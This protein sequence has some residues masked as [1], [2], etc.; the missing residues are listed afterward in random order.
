MLYDRHMESP[1]R[2]E[3]TR[4]EVISER[5]ADTLAELTRSS[6]ALSQRLHPRTAASLAEL[7]RLTNSY[8][9]NL[10][11]GNATRPRDIE[12]ALSEQLDDDR[13]TRDLQRE[14]AAHVRVQREIDE[15]HARGDLEE[16]ATVEF[17]RWIHREFY[18]TA[19]EAMLRIERGDGSSFQMVPGEFRSDPLHDNVVGR[20]QPPSSQAV[21][22]F[23]GYFEGQ[24]RMS[25]VGPARQIVQ[26][27][28]AHHR[29]NHIHPFADGNGR[30]SRLL[31]HAM[32]QRAGIG[33]HGL[34]SIS[35]GLSRGLPGGARYKPMMDAA[36]APREGDL[37][38]R[39]NLSL[40][41]LGEF[42]QWFCDVMLD[43]LAFMSSRLEL[44]SLASRLAEHVERDLGLSP[45]ATAIARDVLVRGEV[46]RGE[47]GRITGL[48]ERA[49]RDV[50]SSLTDSGLLASET[51][52]GPVSLRISAT[53]AE[54]LFPRLF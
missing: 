1:Q 49:A 23:M 16:P 29:F 12:R 50:L 32:A 39:G 25:G 44:G 10:I 13:R 2:I 31:S 8:Y 28:I 3:P 35:R 43:Q 26:V 47:A 46:A 9:S 41:A 53:A 40:A 38:G 36:D 4:L 27:A 17:I 45:A 5:L 18:S 14:A 15:R 19:S 51:P 34:W 52:K 42:V 11:E 24:F 20:H 6:A 54:T 7:L 22:R 33:A 30:V 21:R 37:D 48:R